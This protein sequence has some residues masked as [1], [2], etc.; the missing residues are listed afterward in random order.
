MEKFLLE[1]GEQVIDTLGAEVDRIEL[2]I[3]V[4]TAMEP[5]IK[6]LSRLWESVVCIVYFST[7]W[8]IGLIKICH[9]VTLGEVELYTAL[10]YSL[11]TK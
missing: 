5:L 9:G 7:F 3:K 10:Y 2:G 6:G 1:H 11:P 4:Q 8:S